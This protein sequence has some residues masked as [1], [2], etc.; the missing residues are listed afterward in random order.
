MTNA[1]QKFVGSN[2]AAPPLCVRQSPALSEISSPISLRPKRLRRRGPR[3]QFARLR[4]SLPRH[5][6]TL[7]GTC[8]GESGHTVP[9]IF[10]QF[11]SQGNFPIHQT[12][13]LYES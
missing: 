9:E 8:P 13:I 12:Q 11:S 3:D 2:C 10:D 4:R 7:P 5:R 1:S 6:R